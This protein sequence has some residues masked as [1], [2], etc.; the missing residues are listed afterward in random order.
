MV[1]ES[2]CL[3]LANRFVLSFFFFFPFVYSVCLSVSFFCE[4]VSQSV[5]VAIA[6]A[7]Q[8]KGMSQKEL[9]TAINEKPQV[10][11]DYESGKG[12]I[13]MFFSPS[14]VKNFRSSSI[15]L[16]FASHL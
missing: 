6:Q 4:K 3:Y 14:C 13:P 9:A 15:S 7:R 12:I 1:F 8:A 16:S 11:S 2:V 10:V 5:R